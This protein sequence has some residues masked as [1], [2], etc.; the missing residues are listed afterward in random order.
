VRARGKGQDGC[1]LKSVELA[2]LESLEESLLMDFDAHE[3][4]GREVIYKIG[5]T[6]ELRGGL[7]LDEGRGGVGCGLETVEGDCV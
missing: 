2:T 1:S 4:E 3:G 6:R 7:A 5:R